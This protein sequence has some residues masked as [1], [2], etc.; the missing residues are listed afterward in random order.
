MAM[1]DADGNPYVLPMNFGYKEGI[2]YMHGAAQ[3]KKISFLR[4]RPQVC[5]NFS[6]DQ[7]LRYQ[8]EQVACSWS[9]IYRSV[10]AYGKVSF[11]DDMEEKTAA[12]HIIMAQYAERSFHYN[13]PSL[14]EVNVWKIVTDRLEGRAFGL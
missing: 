3:G 6:T 11:I 10:L 12:L 7:K 2:I 8:S 14:K 13:P 5:V 9:M 4:L 1:C